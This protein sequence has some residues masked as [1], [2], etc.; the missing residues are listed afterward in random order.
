MRANPSPFPGPPWE[1]ERSTGQNR[2]QRARTRA[3][4]RTRGSSEQAGVRAHTRP[5]GG[6]GVSPHQSQVTACRASDLPQPPR[7]LHT[8]SSPERAPPGP[9]QRQVPEAKRG[10]ARPRGLA[11]RAVRV[12]GP[13][14]AWSE[15]RRLVTT[16]CICTPSGRRT[17]QTLGTEIILSSCGQLVSFRRHLRDTERPRSGS[18]DARDLPADAPHLTHSTRHLTA[19][20]L[21]LPRRCGGRRGPPLPLGRLLSS[22]PPSTLYF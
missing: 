5:P 2:A 15:A 10:A 16:V 12:G 11:G 9:K 18:R 13:T 17:C 7:A 1:F 20:P 3:Q 8:P 21:L 4:H 14:Q 22:G 6:E 19:S